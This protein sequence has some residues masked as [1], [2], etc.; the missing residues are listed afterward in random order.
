MLSHG[1]RRIDTGSTLKR[2]ENIPHTSL[3]SFYEIV[4]DGRKQIERPCEE[5]VE[6]NVEFCSFELDGCIEL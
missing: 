3:F 5:D 2:L 1:S 6:R 4:R